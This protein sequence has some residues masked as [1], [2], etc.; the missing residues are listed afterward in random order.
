MTDHLS[1]KQIEEYRQA[2]SVFDKDNDGSISTKDLSIVMH[3]LGQEPTDVLLR[4]MV[5]EV[6][7]DGNGGLEFSEFLR[8]MVRKMRLPDLDDELRIIFQVFDTTQ[9]GYLG[10]QELRTIMRTLNEKMSDDDLNDMITSCDLDQDGKINFQEFV[11]MMN[12]SAWIAWNIMRLLRN[13]EFNSG[14][15]IDC[16]VRILR[17]KVSVCLHILLTN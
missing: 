5:N 8:M 13:R 9:T 6:D 15:Y 3:A 11:H 12:V 14:F 10:V 7:T 16:C 4:D 17:R 1:E 2:F